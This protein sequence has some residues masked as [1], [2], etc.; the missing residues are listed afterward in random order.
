MIFHCNGNDTPLRCKKQCLHCK[1][2]QAGGNHFGKLPP[3]YPVPAII[4]HVEWDYCWCMGQRTR[5]HVLY[6]RWFGNS[7][8][9]QA[10]KAIPDEST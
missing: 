8:G 10:I 7:I 4:I 9:W 6:W 5:I 2:Y 1:R 3:N